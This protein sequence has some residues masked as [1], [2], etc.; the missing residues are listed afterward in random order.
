MLFIAKDYFFLKK[1]FIKFSHA[2]SFLPCSLQR[3]SKRVKMA[4]PKPLR[5][6]APFHPSGYVSSENRTH[7]TLPEDEEGPCL[8]QLFSLDLVYLSIFKQ[9]RTNVFSYFVRFHIGVL[10]LFPSKLCEV[11]D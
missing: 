7:K 3:R 10:F 8:H 5:E 11:S 4:M 9:N 2:I 1:L 6:A